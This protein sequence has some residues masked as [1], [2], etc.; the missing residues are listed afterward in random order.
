[1][2]NCVNIV[3]I[4]T[5]EYKRLIITRK[6]VDE[7][8]EVEKKNLETLKLKFKEETEKYFS[9]NFHHFKLEGF[10]KTFVNSYGFERDANDLINDKN[11]YY[12][13]AQE[14]R[15]QLRN[16]NKLPWYKKLN[17]KFIV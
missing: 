13:Q 5:D 15:I 6:D 4:S 7:Y 17:Y 9:E 14:Y 16:F 12:K 1:M 8:L 10:S 2:S 3:T 11:Y